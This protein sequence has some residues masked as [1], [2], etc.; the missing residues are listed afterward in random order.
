[1]ALIPIDKVADTLILFIEQQRA[2]YDTIIDMYYEGRRLN[3]FLGKRATIPASS[4]PSIEVDG[5]SESIGWHACRVQQE[6][7][8]MSLEITTDNSDPTSAFRLQ[9]ALVSLT[10][11]ILAAPPSLRT[12]IKGTRT[13]LY[14]SLPNNVAYGTAGQGRMRVAT[15]TW[16]GKSLEYLSNRLFDPQLQIAEPLAFPPV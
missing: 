2:V 10:T 1:M 5:K 16:Q 9:A 11:R 3:I 14:D 12:L 15:V 4:L 13:H 7:P 6:E 8:S